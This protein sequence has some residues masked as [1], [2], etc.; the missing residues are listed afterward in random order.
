MEKKKVALVTPGDS[1]R[2]FFESRYSIVEDELNKIKRALGEKYDLFIPDIV[3]DIEQGQ[4]VSDQ[5]KA[6]GINCVI[7]HLPIWATPN[8]AYRIAYSTE[9][10]VLLLGNKRPDSSSIVTLL[11]IA[12]MLEQAGKECIRLAGDINNDKVFNKVEN[13]VI[14]CNLVDSISRSSFGLIGG[15]SI[16]I[17][18]TVADPA[19]W[20]RIFKTE[21]DHCDQYEIVYRAKEIDLKR[22]QLHLNWLK[23]KISKLEFGGLFTEGSLE[24]QVRSYLA[25]KDMVAEKGY[26]F[27]ALKCQQELSDHFA[28]QCISIAL[29]NN[30]YDAEGPKE[31]IPASCEADCDGAMTMKLLSLCADNQ[32]ANL[33]DIKYFDQEKREFILANCGSMAPYFADPKDPEKAMAKI[34]LLPHIFGKAGGA[35]VQMIAK[36][37]R[38]T[39]ARLFRKNGRYIMGCFEGKLEGRPLEEL[40]KTTWCYPHEF[41]K[42]DID[43]E[44]FFQT[45]NS[46]HLHTIYG[47]YCKA[48]ELFCQ[49]KGIEFI[50]YNK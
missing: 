21:F 14:A 35:A 9:L 4:T 7:I 46:N 24:L 12:G 36:A 17:G 27:I 31:V 37:G 42:A 23:E 34:S 44:R 28:L 29:L 25:L 32:P 50:C 15:R 16:G 3:F 33:V 40:H 26:S 11:A 48:L 2:E 1:R 19:Q 18:S 10:P 22:V 45:I 20:Q 38:V 6:R 13:F 39:V 43:Y 49:M 5:I 30:N 8:L 41:V 47:S